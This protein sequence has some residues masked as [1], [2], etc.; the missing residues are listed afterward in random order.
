VYKRYFREVYGAADV[1]PERVAKAIADYERSLVSGDAAWDRWRNGD[2]AAVGAEAKA[3]DA[4]FFGKAGCAQ[5]HGGESFS[6]R[7]FHNLGIGWGGGKEAFADEGRFGVTKDARDRGAFRTPSLRDVATRGPYMHDGSIP[8]LRA[9]VEWHLQGGRPNPGLDS[10][11]MP[12]ALKEGDVVALVRF[13]ESLTSLQPPDKGPA[14]FP[15]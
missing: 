5:C 6:D 4:L 11:I 14:T 3:G 8:T 13:L 7:K 15:R 12:T 10:L 9:A 2:Q 1:T